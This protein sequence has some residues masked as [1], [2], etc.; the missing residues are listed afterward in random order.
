ML[1]SMRTYLLPSYCDF[2]VMQGLASV[3]RYLSWQCKLLSGNISKYLNVILNLREEKKRKERGIH[4]TLR[5]IS[6][7]YF[8]LSLHQYSC[9][10]CLSLT[11]TINDIICPF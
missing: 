10:F 6:S 4:K 9:I 8:F 1:Q 7:C 2:T 3:P 5:D 11:F